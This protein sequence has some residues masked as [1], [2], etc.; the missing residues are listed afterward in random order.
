MKR[1]IQ[2]IIRILS[3]ISIIIGVLFGA[4]WI[5][6]LS[7]PYNSEGRYFD[8]ATETVYTDSGIISYGILTFLFLIIG[9][10][11]LFLKLKLLRR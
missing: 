1:T 5:K 11:F 10:I 4:E 2:Y 8:Q 6:R 3:V 7:L 9:F